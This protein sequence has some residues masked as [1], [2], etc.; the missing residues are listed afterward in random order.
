M[1]YGEPC[2]ASSLRKRRLEE[3]RVKR[4]DNVDV[5]SPHTARIGGKQGHQH[6]TPLARD[7]NT[8]VEVKQTTDRHQ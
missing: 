7:K 5:S 8:Y 2:G 3:E 1:S 6:N 4:K